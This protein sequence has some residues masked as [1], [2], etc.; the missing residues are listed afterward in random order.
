MTVQ[1]VGVYFDFQKLQHGLLGA[2]EL[3]QKMQ[4]SS[5]LQMNDP[6]IMGDHVFP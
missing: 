1:Q 2:T 3:L 5:K 4:P 6:K